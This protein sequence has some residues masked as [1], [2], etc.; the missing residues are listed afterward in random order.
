MSLLYCVQCAPGLGG[1]I[2]KEKFLDGLEL[3]GLPQHRQSGGRIY[4]I[5][6]QVPAHHGEHKKVLPGLEDS[7][8]TS[9]QFVSI[10]RDRDARRKMRLVRCRRPAFV[11]IHP[12]F[13]CAPLPSS[14]QTFRDIADISS[15]RDIEDRIAMMT[16]ID[17]LWR[18]MNTLYV[19][20][21]ARIRLK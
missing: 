19:D 12:L 13:T 6:T 14:L 1:T 9:T 7:M 4:D 3:I 8:M 17:E 2:T 15:I 16:R 18:D 21:R 11:Y 10:F 5:A 20:G